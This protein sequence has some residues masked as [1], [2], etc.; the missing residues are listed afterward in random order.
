MDNDQDSPT[1]DHYLV[2]EDT[3]P[4]PAEPS[5]AGL[6]RLTVDQPEQ[7]G[8]TGSN[9][10]AQGAGYGTRSLLTGG[11]ASLTP[12]PSI[13][14]STTQS[15]CV[16]GDREIVAGAVEETRMSNALASGRAA[17]L[18]ADAATVADLDRPVRRCWTQWAFVPD[19][20]E[21][22]D[23]LGASWEEVRSSCAGNEH[24]AAEGEAVPGR[25][26]RVDTRCRQADHRVDA[27]S[28]AVLGRP[29]GAVVRVGR[30]ETKVETLRDRKRGAV[31]RVEATARAV[32][33]KGVGHLEL[34]RTVAETWAAGRIGT[35][36]SSLER[37][38]CGAQIGS[39]VREPCGDPAPVIDAI[40]RALGQ[41]G[42]ARMREADPEL[43]RGTPGGYQAAI[44][45]SAL[46]TYND[47]LISRDTS[48][49]VP[50]LEIVFYNDHRTQGAGRV[51]LQLAGVQVS[52]T[53]GIYLLPERGAA[54]I[55]GGGAIASR[56]G[57]GSTPGEAGAA[58][59]ESLLAAQ[60]MEARGG[61]I[62]AKLFGRPLLLRDLVEGLLTAGVWLAL[63]LPVLAVTRRLALQ[64][65][66]GGRG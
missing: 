59:A 19:A 32:E 64:R 53:Y 20:P 35:A 34:V 51:I 63:G 54:G 61:G 5:V 1:A 44:Q 29:D 12:D 58:D 33:I 60:R 11:L 14:D 48:Q 27:E 7:P 15:Q 66:T 62:L 25:D 40:N 18:V 39:F 6:D 28:L 41:R 43:A 38:I 37:V 16:P 52:S 26:L 22:A 46:E 30:A 65:A 21:S 49:A 4:V 36:G 31:S 23:A 13:A 42:R 55:V 17:A 9:Y 45:K 56:G 57:G 2:V 8:L 47:S 50:G 24:D 10:E 3:T